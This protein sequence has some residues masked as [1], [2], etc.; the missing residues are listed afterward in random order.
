MSLRF[1]KEVISIS[2]IGKNRFWIGIVAGMI[3]A[4]CLSL[5]VDYSRESMRFFSFRSGDLLILPKE[6]V[7]FFDYFFASFST[8]FGLGLAI[9][10]WLSNPRHTRVKERLYKRLAQTNILVIIWVFLM[11]IA[12][13]GTIIPIVLYSQRGYDNHLDL[14]NDAWFLFVMIPIVIFLN[15]WHTIR[16]VYKSGKWILLSF[17]AVLI[18]T[19]LLA[20]TKTVN[21]NLYND[22]F[23]NRNAYKY[24][25]IDEE[26]KKAS[27]YNIKFSKETK[28]IL[29]QNFTEST[30]NQVADIQNAFNRNIKVSIDTLILEKIIIHH[31]KRKHL[32]LFHRDEADNNWSYAYP[33]QIYEQI[34]MYEDDSLHLHYLFEILHEM[35]F[36]LNA[37]EPNWKDNASMTYEE[38]ILY[39]E[40]RF[41][42][43]NTNTI[44][45]RLL[46]VVNKLK[47]VDKYN[48]Y[49][50]LLEIPNIKYFYKNRWQSEIFLDLDSIDNIYN[51]KSE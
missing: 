39:D 40:K 49:H 20:N 10:I 51:I 35:I 28:R 42:K 12:R 2:I 21:R 7:V 34:K 50:K 3:A 24:N 19:T 46:Q 44:I 5:F 31:H 27:S 11:F 48:K 1:R 32:Y 9:W 36:P 41:Y 33:E 4:V 8:V 37:K 14:Y 30:I 13:W 6:E 23:E 26:F 22:A 45:S 25:Y 43:H 16:Q 15:N 38:W 47:A 17:I 18:I 29:K